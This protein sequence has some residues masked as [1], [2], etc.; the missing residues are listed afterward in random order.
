[1]GSGFEEERGREIFRKY[2][3]RLKQQ[4]SALIRKLAE[5]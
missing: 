1:M 4:T 5:I 2:K 3:K